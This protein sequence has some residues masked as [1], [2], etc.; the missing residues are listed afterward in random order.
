MYLYIYLGQHDY[1]GSLLT[2]RVNAGVASA[3]H[4]YMADTLPPEP[5]PEPPHSYLYSMRA[6]GHVCEGVSRLRYLI[7]G[8]LPNRGQQHSGAY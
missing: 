2:F 6:S 8:D 5:L 1:P 3:P 4:A 7:W